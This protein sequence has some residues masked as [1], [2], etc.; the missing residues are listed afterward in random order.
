M[1][2]NPPS[3]GFPPDDHPAAPV[4]GSVLVFAYGALLDA[5]VV[6]D[7]CPSA[8]FVGVGTVVGRKLE[9]VRSGY[10]TLRPI[11]NSVVHGALW[12]VPAAPHGIGLLDEF[13]GV[14]DVYRRIPAWVTTRDRFSVAANLYVS[15]DPRSGAPDRE[16]LDL[17]VK[18]A[19]KLALPAQ[20]IAEISSHDSARRAA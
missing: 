4:L 9:F 3:I 7:R 11:A 14:P 2:L 1:H 6:R 5:Q 19:M 8:E 18:A 16:Y 12:R 17:I 20:Y 10:A 15:Q 13:E